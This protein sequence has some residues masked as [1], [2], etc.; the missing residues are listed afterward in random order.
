MDAKKL[1]LEEL[2]RD[3]IEEFKAKKKVP[4][5]VVLENIRSGVN[6]GSF[7][8]TADAFAIEKIVLTGITP[9]PPRKEILKTAIGSTSS[10]NWSYEQNLQE[11]LS[12]AECPIIAIEQTDQSMELQSIE[13]SLPTLSKGCVLIF[14]NEVEGVDEKTI[15]E[16]D[17]CIEIPQ[18]GT[19]HSLN[20]SVCA[21][22]VLWEFVKK[23]GFPN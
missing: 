11:F 21:G 20:V 4:I 3:S 1:S 13:T 5:T 23:I 6:V 2:G 15:E 9:T 22:V 16:A 18:F 8:R 7:F 14:G 10:V 19:K 17:Y 12:H